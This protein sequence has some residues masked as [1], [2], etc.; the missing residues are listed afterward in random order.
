MREIELKPCPFCGGEAII[1]QNKDFNYQ[2]QCLTCLARGPIMQREY[3]LPEETAE[4]Y[5]IAQYMYAKAK[6]NKRV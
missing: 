4:E 3:V 5:E 6:W 1:R 2:V